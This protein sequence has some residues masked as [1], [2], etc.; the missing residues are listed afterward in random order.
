[1]WYTVLMMKETTMSTRPVDLLFPGAERYQSIKHGLCVKPPFG[2]GEDATEF[3]DEVS[4][5]EYL[6]SGKCQKCQDAV[7]G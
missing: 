5:K 6:I 4:R 7:F 1:V 2:C 3:R